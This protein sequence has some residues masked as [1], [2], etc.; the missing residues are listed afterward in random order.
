MTVSTA[1]RGGHVDHLARIV[2]WWT[3]RTALMRA[4]IVEVTFIFGQDPTQ[5]TF[6]VDQQ[7]IEAL[8]A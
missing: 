3:E 5:V 7:V 4:M 1:N 8:T 2:Q 6:T